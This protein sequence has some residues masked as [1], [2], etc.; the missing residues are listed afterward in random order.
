MSKVLSTVKVNSLRTCVLPSLQRC[1]LRWS[2]T[3]LRCTAVCVCL[4]C[5]VCVRPASKV[6]R[7]WVGSGGTARARSPAAG[8]SDLRLGK[9]AGKGSFRLLMVAFAHPGI[10]RT[11]GTIWL[12]TNSKSGKPFFGKIK[13]EKHLLHLL[14]AGARAVHRQRERSWSSHGWWCFEN[15]ASERS[16]TYTE[17][18]LGDIAHKDRQ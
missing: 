5:T 13:S 10:Y 11:W 14:L 17:E 16:S 9:R 3:C 8:E 4:W 6:C 2:R 12:T 15:M 7:G 1:S 18:S